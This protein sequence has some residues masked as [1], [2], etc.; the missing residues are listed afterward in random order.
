ME[1]L[2]SVSETSTLDTNI[3]Y[4]VVIIGGGPAGLTAA[5]Y[6]GRYR[7]NFVLFERIAVGGQIT[8]SEWVENYPGFPDGITGTE[9]M[10]NFEKQAIK[11]GAKFV[12][13]EVKR[14]EKKEEIF[15]IE[16][17]YGEIKS[18]TVILATGAEP[19]K[20][21]VKEEEKFRGKGISY[22]ATC[23]AAFF[24]DKSVAVIGGGDTAIIDA[25][26][27][28]KFA[29]NITV[30][31]RRKEL[32][33]AKILQERA[34]NN[35]KIQFE[36]GYIPISI[37]GEKKVEALEIENV[38]T[39]EHKLLYVDG[40]FVAIGTKA[41]SELVKDIVELDERGFV[42]TDMHMQTSLN[43]LFAVGDVRNTPLR[44]VVTAC[45]DA[46]IAV[47]E[48]QNLRHKSTLKR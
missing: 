33:A 38:A 30:V 43:G 14:I 26:T 8:T 29:K 42:K 39:K 2:F 19:I 47:A 15:Y 23:D 1:N 34:L 9:L 36:L 24:K 5:I 25:L 11:F 35:P 27:L 7:L 31:H 41:N 10:Q 4:D 12:S 21:P 45:G 16:T 20:L 32:R 3:V 46:A 37:K 44:Q 18:S 17:G 22:C 48:V 6:A 28:T 40:I 13:T